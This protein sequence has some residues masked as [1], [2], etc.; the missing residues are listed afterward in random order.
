MIGGIVPVADEWMISGTPMAFPADH[1]EQVLAGLPQL[2]M[3]HPKRVFRNPDKLAQARHMQEEQRRAFIDLHGADLIVVPGAQVQ[4]TL[5][6][7]Y[8]YKANR[9]TEPRLPRVTPAPPRSA[10]GSTTQTPDHHQRGHTITVSMATQ[11]SPQV[12]SYPAAA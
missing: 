6:D 11:R 2:V 3:N 5:M 4:P 1:A 9:Y 8:R 7:F 10:N 12:N